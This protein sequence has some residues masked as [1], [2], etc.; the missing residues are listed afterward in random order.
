MPTTTTTSIEH[1]ALE[2]PLGLPVA[3]A[4]GL[5]LLALFAWSLWYERR[6]LGP[7]YT[8]A[9]WLLRSCAVATV[10]WMLLAP[11]NVRVETSTT[12]RAVR[13]VADV[14]G[15]MRTIDPPDAGEDVRWAMSLPGARGYSAA[16]SADRAVAAVGM[17]GRQLQQV[18]EALAQHKLEGEVVEA[19]SSADRA[20]ARARQHLQI[21]QE[22]AS[23]ARTKSAA[24]RG[25]QTL[26]SSEFQAFSQLAASLQSGKT[27]SQKGWRES[28][29]DLADRLAGL[30][31]PLQELARLAADEEA[32]RV[33]QADPS[34]LSAVREAPR[35]G[36]VAHWVG[37]LDPALRSVRDEQADVRLSAFD[38]AVHQ[39]TGPSP[40][41][42]LRALLAGQPGDAAAMATSV[43]AVLRQLQRDRQEQPLAA[44]FLYSDLAHNLTADANP[45]DA[46]RALA[47]T[48][49][50]VVPIG[51]AQHVRDVALQSVHAPAVAMRNDQIVVEAHLRA[52]DCQGEVCTVQLLE[53]GQ[54]VDFREVDLDSGF[55]SRVV[56]FE[57]YVPAIGNQQFQ[58]AVVPL[59]GELTPENN[60]RDFEVNVTRSDIKLLLADELPRWEYRYLA[61]LFRRDAK[62]ECDELLFH[63]RVIA[64][65][66]RAETQT[67]P[68]TVDQ[69]D[70]YD[71]VLLGDLPAEHL[72]VASQESLVEYLNER[73]GTL[74]LI[75][76]QESMPHAFAEHP[77][78]EILPVQPVDSSSA[79]SG[80]FAFRVTDEG[81]EH[82]A[83]MIGETQEA[84]RAAWDFVNRFSPLPAVSAWRKP[85][86]S[87]HVLIAAVPRD[88]LDEQAA[89]KASA[90]LCWQPVGRGR[91]VYLSGPD[92]YRLRFLRGDRLHYRFW[93]QLLRWAIAADLS[94]GNKFVRLRTDRS[95]Y[96]TRE[97]VQAT[98]RLTDSEG[99][100]LAAEGLQLR[101]ASSAEERLVPLAAVAEIPGEYRAEIRSLPAGV[102]RMEA[103]GEAIDKL[104]PGAE[105]ERTSI[106]FTVYAD[107]P[108]EMVDTRCD[109]ALAQQ[110]ADLTGGQVLPP[111][112]V[113]EALALTDLKPIVSERIETRPL[114]REWK[115]LWLVFL[116]LQSEWAIRKWKGWS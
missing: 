96:E 72:S 27:P 95:R 67:F 107:V 106:S 34:L 19:L 92:T 4:A 88:A 49:V 70:Q 10:L 91:V 110:I 17:A 82:L 87:A 108:L 53:E 5:G 1:V 24:G 79:P 28:L 74:I 3:I 100:P 13:F 98:V 116:C 62:V 16:R 90:F 68:T 102:Y 59:E 18:A 104:Q 50:Y 47:G 6:I 41:E 29:P 61:Q 8:A 11:A 31:R 25:L 21:V 40:A 42:S 14:S 35:L 65:G 43:S 54:V 26:T 12:R 51:N 39:L 103:V 30:N 48:P 101:V 93:G 32:S 38:R 97:A 89:E 114:W 33:A 115:Y 57:R 20:L 94:A 9:F 55:A 109:R 23:D 84:T 75:A 113:E 60:Y 80:P 85:K 63:P 2:G 69:W 77:L 52:Y 83:L 99:Q 7:R 112:A 111:T 105:Q 66:R 22:R 76:G 71:L 44:V 81:S 78:A 46:A 73:G 64:T 56:R 45:R 37:A 58:I 15:S 86:P 36:R